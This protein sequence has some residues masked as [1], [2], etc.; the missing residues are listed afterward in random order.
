MPTIAEFGADTS[1]VRHM[2]SVSYK[3]EKDFAHRVWKLQQ[4]DCFPFEA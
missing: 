1:A 4:P 3:Q 2:N